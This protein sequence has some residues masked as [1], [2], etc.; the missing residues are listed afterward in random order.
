MEDPL[1]NDLEKSE[2][3]KPFPTVIRKPE[4]SYDPPG[5][6]AIDCENDV[7]NIVRFYAPLNDEEYW[8]PR[9]AVIMKNNSDGY[10]I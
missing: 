7:H 2:G 3:L 8:V 9:K 4:K 10:Y 6:A 1:A 5:R